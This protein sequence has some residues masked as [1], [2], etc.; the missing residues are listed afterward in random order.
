MPLSEK[1][2]IEVYL[3]NLPRREYQNLLDALIEE[4]SYTFGGCTVLH[5]VDG[6]YLA[7]E[8]FLCRDQVRI[9]YTDAPY[10]IDQHRKLLERYT[11]TVRDAAM[12][13]LDEESILI[14]VVKVYHSE[15]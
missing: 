4:F 11:D 14:A 3:P 1:A 8:G 12:E 13:A 6:S 9:I 5:D 2:R 7:E 15:M 10:S